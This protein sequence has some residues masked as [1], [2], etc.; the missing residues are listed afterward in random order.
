MRLFGSRT[1]VTA[2]TPLDGA[3]APDSKRKMS[4]LSP[5]KVQASIDRALRILVARRVASGHDEHELQV[6]APVCAG[7][8]HYPRW[9]KDRDRIM[10]RSSNSGAPTAGPSACRR[11]MSRS[12]CCPTPP[13]A[14]GA[15]AAAKIV[16]TP[17]AVSGRAETRAAVEPLAMQV[18]RLW[19]H[20]TPASDTLVP[21]APMLEEFQ[22]ACMQHAT[23]LAAWLRR[24]RV[25]A[26]AARRSLTTAR[27][28][29]RASVGARAESAFARSRH[30]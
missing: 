12:S 29:D 2:D 8:E 22:R 11:A 23:P 9:R 24:V 3:I 6:V 15:L 10:Q 21:A 7:G 28:L 27:T 26:A 13:A 14:S 30:A 17:V 16:Y 18:V 19:L 5:A 25:A 20:M 1:S 4:E